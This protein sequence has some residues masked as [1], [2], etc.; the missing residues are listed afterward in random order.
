MRRPSVRRARAGFTLAEVAVTIV[1]IGI[2]LVLCLQGLN[3]SKLQAAYTRNFKLARE[4]ALL[5]LG[6]VGS[7]LYAEDIQD[8]LEGS[9]ADEGHPKFTYEVVVGDDMLSDTED[10]IYGGRFDSWDPNDDDEEEDEE[11]TEQPYEK[12]K[13]RV[14]FT[15]IQDYPDELVLEQWFPWSQ[16]YGS[17]EEQEENR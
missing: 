12:V 4:L 13:I 15:P 1:I 10:D 2:A 16:V 17:P 3:G 7:G 5:T 8:G 14:R 9:Y 11:L 6:E